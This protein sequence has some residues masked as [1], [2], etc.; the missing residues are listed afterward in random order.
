[1]NEYEVCYLDGP[2]IAMV[3]GKLSLIERDGRV[4]TVVVETDGAAT[5]IPAGLVIAWKEITS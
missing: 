5:F 1:M 2:Y 3:T 4:E